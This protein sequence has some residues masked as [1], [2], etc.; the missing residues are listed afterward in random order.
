MA[1]APKERTL[2]ASAVMLVRT[3]NGVRELYWVQRSREVSLGGGFYAFPG[4]RI[5]AAD[6]EL[7]KTLGRPDQD[8]ALLVTALRELFE[9]TGVLLA[10][11]GDASVLPAHRKRLL[12]EEGVFGEVLA[13]VGATLN[14]DALQFAGRWLTP[15]FI[16]TRF[17]TRFYVA[18]VPAGQQPD[19]WPGELAKGEWITPQAAL[20][21]WTQGKALLHPP[22]QHLIE[23]LRDGAVEQ[24][25]PRMRQGPHLIDYVAQ[26]IEFQKGI[27][28][29]PVRTPTLP[30]ATHTNCYLVGE[31]ELVLVDPASPYE[32][33]QARLIALCESLLADGR[34]F[35]EIILTHHHH[36]HVGGVNV[37]REK[38]GIP[39]RA[40]AKTAEILK[41][42]VEVDGFI[43]PDEV[44]VLPG[45]ANLRL[46]AVFTPG[47]APGHLCFFEE[48]T[49]ALITGDMIAGVG[50]IVVDPPEG[51]MSEY[52]ASLQL[53]RSMPVNAIYPAHGPTIPDGP[54]KIDEYL[55]HRAAREAQV[56]GALEKAGVATTE[57]L[58]PFVYTDVPA[59][60][61]PLA[62]RS[63]TAVIDKLVRER[64]VARHPEERFELLPSQRS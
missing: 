36:D 9:E 31:Q 57:E 17:D 51:D 15:P 63:L 48:T 35:R 18:E 11:L 29:A 47:H 3:L 12:E 10:T 13:A 58:V 50:S 61:Y 53:L 39:V 19:V 16:P 55:A 8:G 26:R 49:G 25:L 40:H 22:A 23:C 24:T 27:L 45:E 56:L 62:A 60:L 42:E 34:R 1:G 59:A 33:E 28:L 44:I 46:R 2:H 37:L 7:A 43:A 54:S 41:G 38:L 5:D 6:A 64:R 30:P 20:A 14:L 32:D 4:G 21:R 52:I